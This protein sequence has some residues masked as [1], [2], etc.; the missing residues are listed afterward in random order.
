MAEGNSNA[1]AQK[2]IVAFLETNLEQSTKLNKELAVENAKLRRE[3]SMKADRV[4]SL[5]GA[6]I[7]AKGHT[8]RDPK[9]Q[10]FNALVKKLA[11]K[12]KNAKKKFL[13]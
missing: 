3:L 1:N 9:R 6:L 2:Q 10:E 8:S 7:E 4:S 12:G 13:L 11:E 5:E